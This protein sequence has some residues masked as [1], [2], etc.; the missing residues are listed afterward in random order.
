MGQPRNIYDLLARFSPKPTPED[1]AEARRLGV[2]VEEY[3][4]LKLQAT[5]D[6]ARREAAAQAEPPPAD[7]AREEADLARMRHES[8]LFK[9]RGESPGL[10]VQAAKTPGEVA[11]MILFVLLYLLGLMALIIFGREKFTQLPGIFQCLVLGVMVIPVMWLTGRVWEAIGEGAR[12]ALRL[13]V[14]FWPLTLVAALFALGLLRLA[15]G[16]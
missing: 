13:L 11:K 10:L 6:Q 12:D 14:R 4:S 9:R 2:T 8:G 7:I 3:R 15:F 5:F 16:R 1:E